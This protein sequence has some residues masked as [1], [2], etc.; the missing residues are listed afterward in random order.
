MQG[1]C[2]RSAED[3]YS[4]VA[5]DSNFAFIG[6]PCCPTLDFV[7][8]VWIRSTFYTLLTLL[9]CT[10]QCY[11]IKRWCLHVSVNHCTLTCH[12]IR[13]WSTPSEFGKIIALCNPSG[14][15]CWFLSVNSTHFLWK[16]KISQWDTSLSS[17][18]VVLHGF[19]KIKIVLARIVGAIDS[20]LRENINKPALQKDVAVCIWY[21]DNVT[22]LNKA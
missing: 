18:S 8:V 14:R 2:Y 16:L 11:I 12:Y 10:L 19:L 21:S 20:N 3:A 22:N 15:C 1:V 6:G 17:T 13:V 5:P 7:F 4:P 9:F